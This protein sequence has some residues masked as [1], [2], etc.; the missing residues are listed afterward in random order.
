MTEA[1]MRV[2]I[3]RISGFLRNFVLN[4][5]NKSTESRK[6]GK[7]VTE[8]EEINRLSAWFLQLDDAGKDFINDLSQKLV[9]FRGSFAES[10]CISENSDEKWPSEEENK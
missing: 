3:D 4:Y 1:D 7:N 2:I 6:K 5:E 10:A 8:Q 9:A